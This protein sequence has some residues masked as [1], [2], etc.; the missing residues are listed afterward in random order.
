MRFITFKSFVSNT[1]TNNANMCCKTELFYIK[2]TLGVQALRKYN[3]FKKH[4]FVKA[5]YSILNERHFMFF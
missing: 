5:I 3:N 2:F 4:I 1:Y